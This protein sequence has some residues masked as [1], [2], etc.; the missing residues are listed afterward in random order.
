MYILK[1]CAV[2]PCFLCTFLGVNKCI[3]SYECQFMQAA[4]HQEEGKGEEEGNK[5]EGNRACMPC[6]NL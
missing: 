2:D 6:S 4:L 5:R 1:L 3:S